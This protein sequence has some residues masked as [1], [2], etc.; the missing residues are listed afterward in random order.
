MGMTPLNS[1]DSN[2]LYKLPVWLIIF[3]AVFLWYGNSI[4]HGYS[5][6]DELVTTTDRQIHPLV[7]KGIQGIPALFKR[8]YAVNAEQTYEYRPIPLVTFAVE[9]SLFR[10]IENQA[11]YSHLIQVFLYAIL[12]LVLFKTLRMLLHEQPLGLS[13]AITMVFL[14]LPIHTE[15]VNS[16]KNRDEILSLLFSL[17]ALQFSIHYLQH[18]RWISLVWVSLFFLLAL[19][20]KKTAMPMLVLLPILVHWF[21]KPAW[22]PFAF[23]TASLVIGRLLF[24]LLRKG[25]VEEPMD[26]SIDFVENP[27]ANSTWVERIPAFFESLGWYAKQTLFPGDLKSYYGWGGWEI[28]P[29]VSLSF[30]IGFCLSIAAVLWIGYAYAKSKHREIA[31]GLLFFLVSIFGACNLLFPMVGI[32]AERL[33]FTASL[34]LVIA[35]CCFANAWIPK[36]VPPTKRSITSLVLLLSFVGYASVRVV[37]RNSDW[38]DRI[39]LFR[40]DSEGFTSAKAHALRGQE[41]HAL[42]NLTYADQKRLTPSLRS[43]IEEERMS[44]EKALESYPNYAKIESNLGLL[45]FSFFGDNLKAL[46]CFNH[47]IEVNPKNPSPHHLRI[48][49]LQKTLKDW[50]QFKREKVRFADTLSAY[51]NQ[52]FTRPF[53]RLTTYENEGITTVR[54]GLTPEAIQQLNANALALET[55]DTVFLTT[56]PRFSEHVKK[57]L[58]LMYSGKS[59]SFNMMDQYRLL[60]IPVVE[61]VIHQSIYKALQ[62]SKV[63]LRAKDLEGFKNIVKPLKTKP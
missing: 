39:T 9:R 61:Q 18:K 35:L 57:S 3:A 40:H 56:K 44:Y 28:Q 43:L 23:L 7:E 63:H 22:K 36:W 15:V 12:G 21:F 14:A 52:L 26:R 60:L 16:L 30:V 29:I 4:N 34:G 1:P 5:L 46:N 20:S 19:L 50:M 53:N 11:P 49:V 58:D 17:W 62:E 32:V 13:L 45:Y 27:L 42:V 54:N 55:S 24:V 25:M 41:C 6:D 37:T 31:L 33:A 47:A 10:S 38:K 48:T 8:P 51:K 2:T 59:P